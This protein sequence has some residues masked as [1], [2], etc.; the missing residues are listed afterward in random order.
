VRLVEGI[1]DGDDGVL[2]NKIRE[3]LNAL[4]SILDSRFLSFEAKIIGLISLVI[5]FRGSYIETNLN[6]SLMS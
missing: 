4:L 2:V 6:L 5:E 3:K 1:F